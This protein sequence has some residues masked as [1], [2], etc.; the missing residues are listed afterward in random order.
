MLLISKV[1]R[2]IE[3]Y[4]AVIC[5]TC[6]QADGV[7]MNVLMMAQTSVSGD[8]QLTDFKRVVVAINWKDE[9]VDEVG[10]WTSR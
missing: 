10:R 8:N 4:N 2:P 6:N 5:T 7:S 1:P 9:P 3:W